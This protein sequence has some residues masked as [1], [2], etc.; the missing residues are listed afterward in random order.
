MERANGLH[1]QRSKAPRRK[2]SHFE[3]MVMTAR[4]HDVLLYHGCPRHARSRHLDVND[5]CT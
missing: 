4:D 5:R 1:P 2:V 3:I